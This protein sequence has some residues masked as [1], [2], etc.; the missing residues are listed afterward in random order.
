MKFLLIPFFILVGFGAY[1]LADTPIS[2]PSELINPPQ[3]SS[4]QVEV[5]PP[6]EGSTLLELTNKE[7]VAAGVGELIL[8]QALNQSAADKCADMQAK[9]YWAHDAPDGTTPWYF[10]EQY[11]NYTHAGE[12]LAK[13]FQT[14]AGIVTG[15]MGSPGH[16][17]NLL[18]TKYTYVGFAV[19]DGVL[20]NLVVQH[21]SG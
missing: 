18:A 2:P 17:A 6:I 16:R 12:N 11:T 3:A 4:T 15:W 7:R 5:K 20:D 10:I 1:L 14:N 19:C 13:D 21:F 9:N 8:S